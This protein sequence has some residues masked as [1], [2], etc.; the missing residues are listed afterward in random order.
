[1]RGDAISQH[2]LALS[3]YLALDAALV[4]SNWVGGGYG[5]SQVSSWRGWAEMRGD[6]GTSAEPQSLPGSG[7]DTAHTQM[8]D[9]HPTIQSIPPYFLCVSHVLGND[10][11]LIYQKEGTKKHL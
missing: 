11:E 2:Q 5:W 1:M 10:K 8:A 4:S 7:G 6:G 9:Q 3:R